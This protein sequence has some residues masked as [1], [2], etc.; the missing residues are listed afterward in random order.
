MLGS[1]GLIKRVVAID[2]TLSTVGVVAAE[3]R[4]NHAEAAPPTYDGVV[5]ASMTPQREPV[6]R[7]RCPFAATSR[8]DPSRPLQSPM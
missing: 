8:R 2:V 5:V 3:G 7:C 6:K 1:N 4:G